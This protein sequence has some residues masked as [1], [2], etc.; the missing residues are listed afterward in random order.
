VQRRI[1]ATRRA[2]VKGM[3]LA[4]TAAGLGCGGPSS[5]TGPLSPPAPMG[6]TLTLALMPVGQTVA[7]FDGDF[8][9]A[10]T[11]PTETSVVAVSRVCTHMGC[12]VLLPEAGGRTLDCPCHGSRFTTSG[13]VVNGPAVRPLPSFPA[14]IEGTEVVISVE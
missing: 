8:M 2:F 12:T 14:R 6:R 11:R 3:T 9:L 4:T 1:M 13:E 5:P 7:L 10:V